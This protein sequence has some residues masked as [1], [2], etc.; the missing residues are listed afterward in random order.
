MYKQLNRIEDTR[1]TGRSARFTLLASAAASFLAVG[2]IAK[3]A[4]AD[5]PGVVT[6]TTLPGVSS[7]IGAAQVLCDSYEGSG[8]AECLATAQQFYNELQVELVA[9][10]SPLTFSSG[11]A[12][13]G[14]STTFLAPDGSYTEGH[15][16][17]AAAFPALLGDHKTLTAIENKFVYK[18]LDK[19]T[20][21]LI[22]D[23]TWT[24]KDIWTH[25][26][27][28]FQTVQFS[29]YTRRGSAACRS[30]ASPWGAV[31]WSE[32]SEVLSY[33]QP[34][35]G[36]SSPHAHNVGSQIPTSP[37]HPATLETGRIVCD[38]AFR[39]HEYAEDAGHPDMN[40]PQ[41]AREFYKEIDFQLA[42]LT[43]P[44]R[45]ADGLEALDEATTFVYPTGL[46]TEGI[47]ELGANL[48]NLFGDGWAPTGIENKFLYKPIDERTV[49]F[50]GD[51]IFTFTYLV[52][53]PSYGTTKTIESVQTSVYRRNDTP[54]GNCRSSTNPDGDVCW[55]ELGEQWVY[56]QSVLGL[57][58]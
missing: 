55:T 1:V 36:T 46:C 19:N 33:A 20:V 13:V 56:G 45:A 32:V 40:C 9:L 3:T 16:G 48:G 15:H 11:L 44:T 38:G 57:N 22:G 21:I 25:Q 39:S 10:T 30:L 51:P 47:S 12:A 31:C 28:S 18:P 53:G 50:I 17:L 41:V 29:V 7:P 49:L 34:F 42:T 52:P 26:L 5:G 54:L 8:T 14:P 23:P 43:D 27:S 2:A 6:I 24:V 4:A 37:T 35:G 58:E